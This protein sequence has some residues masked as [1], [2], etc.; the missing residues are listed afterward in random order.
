[1]SEDK[2]STIIVYV[3]DRE[4]LRRLTRLKK[5]IRKKEPG[6]GVIYRLMETNPEVF[7]RAVDALEKLEQEVFV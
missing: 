2:L 3:E 7:K 4:R 5:T 1:M 6:R